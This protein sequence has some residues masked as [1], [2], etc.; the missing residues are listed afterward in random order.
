M[1]NPS[2]KKAKTKAGVYKSP[3]ESPLCDSLGTDKGKQTNG[4]GRQKHKASKGTKCK[5]AKKAR[6]KVRV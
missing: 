6:T 4:Q 1:Q 2:G 3:A 5:R